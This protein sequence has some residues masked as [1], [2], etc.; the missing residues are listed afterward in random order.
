MSCLTK[1]FEFTI[2][3]VRTAESERNSAISR[4]ADLEEELKFAKSSADELKRVQDELKSLE[5]AG[6]AHDEDL[7]ALLEPIMTNLSG[8]ITRDFI[9]IINLCE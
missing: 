2:A 1:I 9:L 3:A 4:I 7:T 8:K 6:Q 5:A